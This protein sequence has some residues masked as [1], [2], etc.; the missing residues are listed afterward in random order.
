MTSNMGSC[1]ANKP[2][3]LLFILNNLV[4]SLVLGGLP[5]SWQWK[6]S[7]YPCHYPY[8]II[9]LREWLSY[10]CDNG[11]RKIVWRWWQLLCTEGT[12][13]LEPPSDV[14]IELS[15]RLMIKLCLSYLVI[16][17]R[18][19]SN[20]AKDAWNCLWENVLV[21]ILQRDRSKTETDIY[22]ERL[23]SVILEVPG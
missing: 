18:P 14:P 3:D 9:H 15:M 8:A 17:P 2:W 21:K 7:H 10:S 1:F 11:G 23:V 22:Y 19:S 6:L 4:Q 16:N 5:E 20:K 13:E 12:E